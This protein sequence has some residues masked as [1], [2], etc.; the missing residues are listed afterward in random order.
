MQK[1]KI[2]RSVDSPSLWN[3][4]LSPGWTKEE[5]SV[6]RL[7]VMKFG[8]G[9]HSKIL[10]S[11]CLPGKTKAQINLQTQKLLGQ[12]SLA[13]FMSIHLDPLKVREVNEQKLNVVRKNGCIINTG[14]NLT[15]EELKKRIEENKKRF[16]L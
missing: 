6:L 7:A 3:T 15:K 5:V 2:V 13:E 16:S 4:T 9:K 12:Q 8:V 1:A 10:D 11:G 14:N